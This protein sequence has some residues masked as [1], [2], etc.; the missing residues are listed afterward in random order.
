[1]LEVCLRRSLASCEKRINS[2]VK[3]EGRRNSAPA[4]QRIARRVNSD[5]SVNASS[6]RIPKLPLLRTFTF[7]LMS[8]IDFSR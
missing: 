4:G 7:I 8:F 2:Y 3:A 1:M 5:F 6:S